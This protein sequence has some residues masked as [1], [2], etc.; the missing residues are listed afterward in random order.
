M[1]QKQK[2]E[3]KSFQKT[4]NLS[5]LKKTIQSPLTKNIPIFWKGNLF[6]FETE[7]NPF[8]EEST[9]IKKKKRFGEKYLKKHCK[10]K[11]C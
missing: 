4:E 9:L 6:F 3:K 5:S 1:F 8:L 7:N 10:T 2:N 11:L